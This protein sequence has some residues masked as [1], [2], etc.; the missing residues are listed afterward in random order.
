MIKNFTGIGNAL[1]KVTGPIVDGLNNLIPFAGYVFQGVF[2]YAQDMIVGYVM[3]NYV[4][5]II[6]SAIHGA[7]NFVSGAFGGATSVADQ[8]L[9]DTIAQTAENALVEAGVSQAT[10]Q[11]VVATVGAVVSVIG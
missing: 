6:M 7:I 2:D 9:G 3:Q 8:I 10:A 5:P 11:S 1:D 4:T